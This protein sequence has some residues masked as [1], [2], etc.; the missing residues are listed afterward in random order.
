MTF[1]EILRLIRDGEKP[2]I[3]LSTN[4]LAPAPS[5]DRV[6][7]LAGDPVVIAAELTSR[8]VQEVYVDGG[9]TIQRF[10]RPGSCD[11]SSSRA[12]RC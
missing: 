12:C 8:G 10:M 6:E 3:V 7:H 9:E 5:G 2:V 4:P 1:V 11:D